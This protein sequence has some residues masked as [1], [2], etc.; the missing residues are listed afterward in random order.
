MHLYNKKKKRLAL[1]LIFEF[2]CSNIDLGL[3]IWG[4]WGLM[5]E[6][7]MASLQIHLSFV[8]GVHLNL[9]SNLPSLILILVLDLILFNY[10][11]CF[12]GS[13]SCWSW[14]TNIVPIQTLY[15]ILARAPNFLLWHEIGWIQDEWKFNIF[16]LKKKNANTNSVFFLPRQF[17]LF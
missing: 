16:L 3:I 14:L 6:K 1:L 11:I 8:S 5:W 13:L 2:A 17:S 9:P 15:F 10:F 12:L 7:T 4:T